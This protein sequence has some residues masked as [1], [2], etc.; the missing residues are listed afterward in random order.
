MKTAPI[1][2]VYR[3]L[4][5]ILHE[6]ELQVSVYTSNVNVINFVINFEWN[7]YMLSVLM[8]VNSLRASMPILQIVGA[9][10]Q[11]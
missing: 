2:L 1:N 10:T 4:S 8:K 7:L 11:F 6:H 3:S 5:A 9:F